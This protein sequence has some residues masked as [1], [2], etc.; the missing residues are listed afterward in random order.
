MIGLLLTVIGV[1]FSV[2]TTISYDDT[3]KKRR[4]VFI[5]MYCVAAQL[6]GAILAGSHHQGGIMPRSI[7]I[8]EVAV[9]VVLFLVLGTAVWGDA[10]RAVVV[11]GHNHPIYGGMG[12]NPKAFNGIFALIM[13]A[14]VFINSDVMSYDMVL[15]VAVADSVTPVAKFWWSA[16][17]VYLFELF[18]LY[19]FG[20][21]Y[22]T[23]DDNDFLTGLAVLFS[24][25]ELL[26]TYWYKDLLTDEYEKYILIYCC[27]VVG[28]GLAVMAVHRRKRH[29]EYQSLLG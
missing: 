9:Q 2:L 10:D 21:A 23:E 8:A 15:D 24:G 4:L 14:S 22:G 18:L 16:Y 27:V 28:V 13:L 29:Y 7:H 6:A 1:G 20:V 25:G 12:L 17:S 3:P 19:G 26:Q 11:D 5:A